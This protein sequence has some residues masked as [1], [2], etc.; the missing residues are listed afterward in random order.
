M[1]PE[2]AL[3]KAIKVQR[4]EAELSQEQLA[5]Q[6]EVDRT[7]ISNIERGNRQPSYKTLRLI[8]AALKTKAS[9]LIRDAEQREQSE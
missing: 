5:E 1:T 2:K 4:V 7:Y 9:E 6:C 8:A 3:G